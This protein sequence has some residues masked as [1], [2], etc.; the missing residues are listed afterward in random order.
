MKNTKQISDEKIMQLMDDLKNFIEQSQN[1]KESLKKEVEF[2]EYTIKKA[3]RYLSDRKLESFVNSLESSNIK[4]KKLL[5]LLPIKYY[6]Y[7]YD[8]SERTINCLKAAD[9]ET[10]GDLVQYK[11]KDLLKLRNFGKKSL[12]EVEKLVELNGLEFGMELL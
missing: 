9:I 7:I 6:Y 2:L 11:K 12:Y 8:L 10:L 1:E 3:L 5:T 4:E